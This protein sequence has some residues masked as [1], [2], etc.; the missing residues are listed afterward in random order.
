MM[1]YLMKRHMDQIYAILM[2]IDGS[3]AKHYSVPVK[4]APTPRRGHARGLR[5]SAPAVQRCEG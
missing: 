1:Q 5:C 3:A 2:E 4:C